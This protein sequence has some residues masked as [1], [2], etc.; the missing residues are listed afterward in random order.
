MSTGVKICGL[1]TCQSIDAAIDAGASHYGLVFFPK[2]PRNVTLAEAASLADHAR[3]RIVAVALTVDAT[4]E[5]LD[6]IARTVRPDMLQLHGSET[7]ERAA[8]IRKL[9]GLPVIKAVSI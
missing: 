9:T 8:Q 2:S 7:P 5:L 3:G 6:G 1:R 4:D